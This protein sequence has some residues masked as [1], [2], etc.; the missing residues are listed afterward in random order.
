M[1]NDKEQQNNQSQYQPKPIE[2]LTFTDNGMFQAVLHNPKICA[3]LVERLLNVKVNQVKYPKLEKRIAPYYTSKGVRLDVYLKDSDKILDIEMQSRVFTALG[4]RTRYYQSMIDIDALMKGE[5][6]PNLKESYILFIC[7][8]DPFKDENEKSFTM[9]CYTFKNVCLE[10]SEVNLNDKALKV[11]YNASA[12]E[13][14]EDSKIRE[15]LRFISTNNPGE[16]DFTN[17]IS[18]LVEKI[19]ENEKFRRD[20]AAMNLHDFDIAEEAKR[21]ATEQKSVEDAVVAVNAFKVSPQEAAEKMNAP[22][23]KVLEA[24]KSNNNKEFA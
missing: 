19:K 2:E 6:Y 18:S 8:E 9:P 5:K 20:Y 16:D 10:N 15:F 7:K 3:E 17:R 4:K 22:L 1:K 14:A 21:E 23:E 13:K 12:Y 24:L 11:I